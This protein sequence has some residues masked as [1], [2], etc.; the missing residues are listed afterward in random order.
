MNTLCKGKIKR[1]IWSPLLIIITCLFCLAPGAMAAPREIEDFQGATPNGGVWTGTITDEQVADP[2]PATTP[3]SCSITGDGAVQIDWAAK[4]QDWTTAGAD[5]DIGFFVYGNNGLQTINIDIVEGDNPT[6]L[7]KVPETWSLSSPITVNWIGWKYFRYDIA[8]DFSSVGGDGSWNPDYDA[9]PVTGNDGVSQVKFTIGNNVGNKIYIDEIYVSLDG[10][11]LTL[12]GWPCKIFP[13]G[14]VE[15]NSI[16]ITIDWPPPTV[17]AVFDWDP[18]TNS[19]IRIVNESSVTNCLNITANNRYSASV[20]GLYGIFA[21]PDTPIGDGTY[22]IFI[23]P[24]DGTSRGEAEV[25]R[26]KV[27]NA[28]LILS[29]DIETKHSGTRMY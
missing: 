13:V 15:D 18:T 4:N 3:Q 26:F 14:D 1:I 21:T 11:A 25:V 12:D 8:S 16:D 17:S 28:A 5:H 22:T 27:D 10:S 19:T 9:T 20:G 23:V 29:T 2:D 7:L 6:L 24:C